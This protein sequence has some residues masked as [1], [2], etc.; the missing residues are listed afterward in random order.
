MQTGP[1]ARLPAGRGPC[2]M[3]D[4]GG[5]PPIPSTWADD[6]HGFTERP[7]H[8]PQSRLRPA[9]A[10]HRLE[11]VHRELGACDPRAG[12]RARRL[13]RSRY[14]PPPAGP[15]DVGGRAC[16]GDVGGGRHR[17][18][19]GRRAGGGGERGRRDPPPRRPAGALL[20]RGSRCRRP[21]Q[22]GGHG[23]G[24][25]GSAPP[26]PAP[27][28]LCKLHRGPRRAGGEPLRGHPLRRLQGLR[29]GHRADLLAGLGRCRASRSGRGSSTASA[30]TRA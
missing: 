7:L 14:Q 25:R 15:A 22:R 12:R 21:R 3:P 16:A 30:A 24:V 28:R 19:R 17:R 6:E 29:R 26:R 2:R 11:R 27:H 10:R 8:C 4:S 23:G 13:L 18:C 5:P 1:C 9:R 20:P